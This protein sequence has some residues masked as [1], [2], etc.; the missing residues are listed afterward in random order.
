[1]SGML[2]SISRRLQTVD[3]DEVFCYHTVKEVRMLDR[4]LGYLCW[5]IRILIASYVIGYVF[6]AQEGYSQQELAV[7]PGV[8]TMFY[9]EWMAMPGLSVPAVE[10]YG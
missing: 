2:N 8:E 3:L 9:L 7:V 5:T 4:R 6:I 10:P 1:M